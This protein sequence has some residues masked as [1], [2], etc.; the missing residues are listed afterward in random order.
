MNEFHVYEHWRPDTNVCF[1]VGKGR[2]RRA[3]DFSAR[4]N[5]HGKIVQKLRRAGLS[6]E[7]KIVVSGLTDQQ[8]R[9]TEIIHIA[10]LRN[11]GVDLCNYTDGG[12]GTAGY[13][14]TPKTKLVLSDKASQRKTIS[15]ETRKLMSDTHRGTTRSEKTKLKMSLSAK[16]AQKARAVREMADPVMRA[17]RLA[18]IKRMSQ[19]GYGTPAYIANKRAAVL[20]RWSKSRPVIAGLT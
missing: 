16:R 14:H 11:N 4:N 9:E 6:V 18:T 1:Y 15:L 13:K 5:R 17:K 8:A 20:A 2:L 19:V 12:D 7:L 10:L 3:R